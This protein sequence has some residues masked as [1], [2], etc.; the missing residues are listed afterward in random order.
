M[1]SN[2]LLAPHP[3]PR[4]IS[5]PPSGFRPLSRT[6][7]TTPHE[8][9]HER[10]TKSQDSMLLA[11]LLVSKDFGVVPETKNPET[12]E[13]PEKNED[14]ISGDEF[15][16]DDLNYQDVF[17]LDEDK[18]A[19]EGYELHKK[20]EGVEFNEEP[21]A[22]FGS[23]HKKSTPR[24]KKE[25][26]DLF[27]EYLKMCGTDFSMISKFFPNRTRKM[28]VNKFHCEERKGTQKF[29]DAINNPMSLDVGKFSKINGVD[30]KDL[31][32][33]FLKNKDRLLSGL[34]VNRP[35]PEHEDAISGEDDFVDVDSDEE[36]E[37][38]KKSIVEDDES[39]QPEHKEEQTTKTNESKE[40]DEIQGD[41]NFDSD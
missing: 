32:D 37:E 7:T 22:R 36:K 34:P 2:S 26:T 21:P 39:E 38:K 13:K 24:W 20:K 35:A 28:I 23:K 29:L 15:Q 14:E 5:R 41:D 10:P 12:E 16:D 4:P 27:Y 19:A 40:D 25:E 30:E 3:N 11:N 31:V 6:L 9:P 17:G 18:L 8:H 33:D 1:D